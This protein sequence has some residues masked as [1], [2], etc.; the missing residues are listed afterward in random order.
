MNRVLGDVILMN[1][2][3]IEKRTYDFIRDTGEIQTRYLHNDRMSG[4][5]ATLQDKGLVVVYE[6]YTSIYQR[7]KK[8][9]VRIK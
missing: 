2:S 1:L 5:V 7:K 9:S 6:K 8:K 4:A 3:R